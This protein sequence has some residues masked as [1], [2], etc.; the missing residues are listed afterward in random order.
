[1]TCLLVCEAII[2]RR[3]ARVMKEQELMFCVGLGSAHEEAGRAGVGEGVG[4]WV[5][6]GG[7]GGAVVHILL[8]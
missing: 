2:G 8:C 1:M 4:L 3:A 6:G 7:G 5:P